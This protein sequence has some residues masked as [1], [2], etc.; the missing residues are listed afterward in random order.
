MPDI[1]R[2]LVALTALSWACAPGVSTSKTVAAAEMASAKVD[3]ATAVLHPTAGHA[4]K[5]TVRLTRQG[6]GIHV[7]AHVEGLAP[8]RHGFHVH[9]LG[10]CST[11]DGTSAGGHFDPDG[12][13]HAAREA[14]LR[15]V[16]DLGN[17]VANDKGIADA[18]FVDSVLAFEGKYSILGRA[19]IVHAGED[20]LKSQPSGA[21]GAR[22]AC[23]VIGIAAH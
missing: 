21:A 19:I 12:R 1:R 17:V 22:V 14:A 13:P 11:A 6:A 5:G 23:G 7:V 15:H 20:D 9:E 10:D 3:A 4:V 18:E 2:I 8:G 16:G